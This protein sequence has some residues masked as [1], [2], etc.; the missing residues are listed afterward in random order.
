MKRGMNTK[1]TRI[2]IMPDYGDTYAWDEDNGAIDLV[3][4]FPDHP[5]VEEIK[6]I[7]SRLERLAS[8]LWEADDLGDRFPWEELHQ[9]TEALAGRLAELLKGSGVQVECRR[10]YNDPQMN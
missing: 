6:K 4:C 7:D 2:T 3:S 1:P 10:H 8:R 5:Q 9:E